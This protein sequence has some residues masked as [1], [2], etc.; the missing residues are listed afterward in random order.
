M[1]PAQGIGRD[2]SDAA[3]SKHHAGWGEPVEATPRYT[4][5]VERE[6]APERNKRLK[7]PYFATLN[8]KNEAF[9]LR[10]VSGPAENPVLETGTGRMAA[11]S[12]KSAKRSLSSAWT[13]TWWI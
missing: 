13:A 7:K 1:K 10:E 9:V 2:E 3:A 4:I 12:W 11:R 8:N 5:N 6:A